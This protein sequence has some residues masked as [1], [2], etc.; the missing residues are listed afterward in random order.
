MTRAKA[1]AW[2]GRG[3]VRRTVPVPHRCT[4]EAGT[5]IGGPTPRASPPASSSPDGI[6]SSEYFS[7][8]LPQFR[9]SMR[10]VRI[11]AQ[12]TVHPPDE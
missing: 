7:D 2:S 10:M 1:E 5:A 6:E 8:E 4:I 9:E 11:T 3:T 12:D